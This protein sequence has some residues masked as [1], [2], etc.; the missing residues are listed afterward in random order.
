MIETCYSESTQHMNHGSSHDFICTKIDTSS[1]SIPSFPAQKSLSFDDIRT[2]CSK[3]RLLV[4]AA[5][6]ASWSGAG[7]ASSEMSQD[8]KGWEPGWDA[9]REDSGQRTH[10]QRLPNWAP[11]YFL[12]GARKGNWPAPSHSMSGRRNETETEHAASKSSTRRDSW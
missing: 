10:S 5:G 4:R 11:P 12:L 8:G 7:H 9:G 1:A 6:S 3:G 2:G